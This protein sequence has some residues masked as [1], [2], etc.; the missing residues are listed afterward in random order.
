MVDLGLAYGR[1]IT[2]V[3]RMSRGAWLVAPARA[4]RANPR[5]EALARAGK[6]SHDEAVAK[7]WPSTTT[8]KTPRAYPAPLSFPARPTQSIPV[9]LV[10]ARDYLDSVHL[11]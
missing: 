1:N 10:P 2:C 7:G 8:A 3:M 11:T 4:F 6:V 5:A 9:S